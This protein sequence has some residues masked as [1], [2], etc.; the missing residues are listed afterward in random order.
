MNR[1]Q[2]KIAIV[3]GGGS[4]IGAAIVEKFREEGATVCVFDIKGEGE[5]WYQVDVTKEELIN[6]AVKAVFERYGRIDILVNNAGWAGCNLP[7]HLMDVKGWDKT[8]EVDVKGVMLCTKAVL[9]VMIEQGGGS[10]IN[11]ASIYATHGTVGDVTAYHA[12]KGAVLALTK[13]DATTY[14][15]KGVRVNAIL[16]GPIDTPLLRAFGEAV[17]GGWEAYDK[18]VSKHI[19]LK[20]LGKPEDIAYGAVFLASDESKYV[21]GLSMYID[22]GYTVW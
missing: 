12:A 2:N 9:P 14:G 6:N 10:I 17:P 22:G 18:Y 13:Q 8:F 7:T 1:L 21:T 19:P 4:G 16:P 3:T 20:R 5:Y 11:M 15:K